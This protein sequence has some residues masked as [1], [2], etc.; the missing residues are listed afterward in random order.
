[1][2]CGVASGRKG[3]NFLEGDE[4]IVAAAEGIE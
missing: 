2:V 1:L 3:A 4:E